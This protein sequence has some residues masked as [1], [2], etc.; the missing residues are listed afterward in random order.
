[1][2]LLHTDYQQLIEADHPGL[3]VSIGLLLLL[4]PHCLFIA[5]CGVAK[6]AALV[7]RSAVL[8]GLTRTKMV[9]I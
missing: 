9:P 7:E 1:M 2:V 5:D 8:A 4:L 6:S 3:L